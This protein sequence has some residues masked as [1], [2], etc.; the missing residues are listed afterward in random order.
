MLKVI[1]LVA[2]GILVQGF[3]IEKICFVTPEF[4]FLGVGKTSV[5][6]K[7]F[8]RFFNF[9]SQIPGIFN[10]SQDTTSN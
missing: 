4:K 2:G 6:L 3:A 8:S 10:N 9:P 7:R 5:I 1:G